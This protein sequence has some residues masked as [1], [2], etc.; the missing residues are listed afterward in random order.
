MMKSIYNNIKY[1]SRLVAHKTALGLF[2]LSMAVSGCG[3]MLESD[4]TRQIFGGELDSKTDS[5]FFALGIMQGMQQLADQYVFQGE[6]RGDNVATTVCTDNNLRQLYNFSATAANRYDSAYV[7]YRVINN[8]NY[9]IA[10][11]DTTLLTGATN[12][13]MNEYAAVKAFRAWAYL[14]L[15]RNYGRVPFFTEPLTS[16][17]QIDN[18]KYPVLDIYDIVDRLAPD[19]EQY[20]GYAVPNNG[21]GSH[22][23]GNTNIGSAKS[24]YTALCYIPVDV[25][26]GEL[27]LEAG[28][29]AKAAH[30]Y[31]TYIIAVSKPAGDLQ[32]YAYGMSES[33]YSRSW[34]DDLNTPA[35]LLAYQGGANWRGIFAANGVADIISYIPMAVNR[36]RGTTT[37]VP[38]AFGYN[39]YA[40]RNSLDELYDDEIQLMPSDVLKTLSDSTTYYYYQNVPGALPQQY[41]K[42]SMQGD[43]RLKAITRQGTGEDSTKLWV[44][45]YNNGNIILYRNTTV[46]LH[47][48]E[49]L[50]R[51]GH[52]DLA[53]A[54]LK[55][56][57]NESLLNT[58]TEYV[59]EASRQLLQN[60]YP[61]LSAANRSKFPPHTA[62]N[63]SMTNW[64][65]HQHGAGVTSDGNFP[66]RSGYQ[67]ESELSRKMDKIEKEFGLTVGATAQDTLQA[68]INAMEDLL[69]DE[70]Q[71]E[72]A[73]EGTRWYDLMRLARHK[74]KAATF[75][76][77]FGG[78]WLARKLQF[79]NPVKDLSN[80]ENWFLPLK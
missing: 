57:I 58:T 63:F 50:N 42:E 53:F 34:R 7:Y 20:T 28:E 33:P 17:S 64:G 65:I 38:M 69:C 51:L 72:F 9:Y 45:K 80:S 67:Y 71:L 12:V 32:N 56:G 2:C 11:R 79:K 40:T 76:V 29:F 75:G 3:D 26:L 8:C 14:Q 16:I 41:V 35:D 25:I 31:T 13:V 61:F 37:N 47:L 5:M 46:Y 23:I 24:I 4:N 66:G 18:N 54:I 74:N 44:Q 21:T 68:R 30:H 49:A 60:E 39:Y 27:Y 62:S 1:G 77:N 19:L 73:F 22:A 78:K 36:L 48:A 43:Q 70:Y 10:H 15:V 55:E 52:P 6:L 59:T